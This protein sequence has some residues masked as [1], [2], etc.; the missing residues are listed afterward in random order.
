MYKYLTKMKKTYFYICRNDT[1]GEV[2]SSFSHF[3]PSL[4]INFFSNNEKAQFNKS[5]VMFSPEVR[6]RDISPDCKDGYIE[7]NDEITIDKLEMLFHDQFH[8]HAEISPRTG[9]RS[10]T[11]P[12]IQRSLTRQNIP[13]GVR[14]PERSHIAHLNNVSFGFFDRDQDPVPVGMRNTDGAH[15]YDLRNDRHSYR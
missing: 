7:L 5:C 12:Q 6:V 8:L 4:E 2:Q 14:L 10:V 3:Y 11:A 1:I 9:K 15:A 13:A